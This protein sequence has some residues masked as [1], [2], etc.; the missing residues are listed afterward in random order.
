MGGP[1][2]EYA[3]AT[4]IED[5]C[6]RNDWNNLMRLRTDR[7]ADVSCFEALHDTV[8]SC[9]PVSA[10][11]G[12]NNCMDSVDQRRGV[13]QVGLPRTWAA[14]AYVDPANCAA[15]R[16]HDRRPGE[17]ALTVRGVVADLE[18]F[19]HPLI[20]TDLSAPVVAL[21]STHADKSV[22]VKSEERMPNMC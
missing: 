22:M 7:P 2:T 21:A 18:P 10:A 5:D 3:T 17:P 14:A 13:E 20:L 9:Q 6:R 4:K 11:T 16:Q 19:N 15:S 1:V 8:R 12:E